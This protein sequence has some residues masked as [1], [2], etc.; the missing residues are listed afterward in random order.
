[1]NVFNI[2]R[3]FDRKKERG[4]D[5]IW[6]MIDIHD[7]IFKGR[8]A[9]DQD[10]DIYDGCIEVLKWISGRNDQEIILWTSSY[11]NDAQRVMTYLKEKYDI[12]VDYY[13]ENPA[14]ENTKLADFSVKPYFNIGIDDKFGFVGETDW[15][16]IKQ[17]LIRIGE[18]NK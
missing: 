13:N 6:W 5:T 18:W 1:M 11:G 4:W 8:Y 12:N 3:A 7:T 14:C 15:F 9:S 16:L 10:F 17:E 2:E